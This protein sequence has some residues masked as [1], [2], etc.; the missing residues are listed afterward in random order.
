MLELL[1]GALMSL[2]P[3]VPPELP[4]EFRGVWVATVDNIDWPSRPGL[5]I[6]QQKEQL[7]H[8]IRY[9]ATLHFNAIIFQ[10]RPHCD[11]LYKSEYEPSSWY[12]TGE[13]GKPMGWDPL[14]YAVREAHKAGL[15]V[16][17]WFNPYRAQH[18]AQ[19]GPYSEDHVAS[20]H[21]DWIRKFGRYGWL[22][23]GLKEVR[24]HTRDVILDVVKRYDIDGVHMDDYFYPYPEDGVTFADDATFAQ[25]QLQGGMLSKSD[26]RR[27]N[28]DELVSG[29]NEGIH[30][31]KP[32]VKFGISPF[33]IYR[34]NVPSG[35]RAGVDQ[36]ED[37]GADVLKWWT[38]GWCDYISPQLY[39]K[40][41][42]Q[43][44]PFG[45]LFQWW[46]ANNPQKR[47]LWP[48]LYTG[49]VAKTGGNWPVSEVDTQISLTRRVLDDRGQVHFSAKC[50]LADTKGIATD[51][52]N[53]A[54]KDVAL[55]PSSPWLG[56][57][58]VSKP[59]LKK[60]HGLSLT[61]EPVDNARFYAVLE[62]RQG[63]WDVA[64]VGDSCTYGFSSG[65]SPGPETVAVVAVS[66]TGETSEPAVI[67][68]RG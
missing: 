16:H 1:A 22:D 65:K 46:S 25:Y 61:W 18:P 26:W 45:K 57:R 58:P 29:L 5:P 6:E 48:G 52:K 50:L 67:R 51:L 44:Q 34:P 23:P 13:Q 66:R 33:G 31:I 24:D 7:G 20:A 62:F 42:S 3:S 63:V 12:V 19:K 43:Y 21:P 41:T 32:W 64:Q 40:S 8:L 11:A 10:V 36:F 60:D 35:I 27:S 37:L 39:W 28:V 14:E 47:H 56:T 2:E 38:E 68:L 15:E 59:L 49:Q 53:G 4:R 17:A 9:M 54:Y 55:V 30:K